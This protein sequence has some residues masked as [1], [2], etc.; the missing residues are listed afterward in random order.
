MP[1]CKRKG[2]LFSF[3]Q[4][5]TFKLRYLVNDTHW[6]RDGPIFFYTGNEGDI[7]T[8]A[9]NT[10]FVWEIADQFSALIL[11]AEHRY[12]GLSL[13]FGN[14]SYASPQYVGYLTSQQAL[15]DYVD[16]IDFLQTDRSYPASSSNKNPVIAFGGSYG[17]ML[18]AWMRMKYPA[19]ILGA[20]A[21][22]APVL[23]FQG[24]VPCETFNRI[25]TSIFRY[26]GR[27]DCS[28]PIRN[29]WPDIQ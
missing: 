8:F 2:K 29:S 21:S 27:S 26:A 19:T 15:A 16:L 20:I 10:G 14:N 18:S 28:V 11:F 7:E 3:T 9:Q 24:L 13:P 22:S 5:A 25:V 1:L 23:Q 6:S 12:Y 17:G 4:N